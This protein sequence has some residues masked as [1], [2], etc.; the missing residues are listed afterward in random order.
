LL[1]D[2][3]SLRSYLEDALAEAYE[4]GRNLAM[5]ETDLA[6][7]TFP[8][9]CP[10]SLTEILGDSEALLQVDRFYPGEASELVSELK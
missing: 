8:V 7:E 10:Y 3:P 6:E 5:G 9:E 4:N 1:K 2:N